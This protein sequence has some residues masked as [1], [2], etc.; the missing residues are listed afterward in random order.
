[1]TENDI[2]DSAL[3]TA[4]L[5]LESANNYDNPMTSQDCADAIR[6]LKLSD[7]KRVRNTTMNWQPMKTAP[8]DGTGIMALLPDSDMAV[9]V[10]FTGKYWTVAWDGAIL[11]RNS[12]PV[13]WIH[14][15]DSPIEK[16]VNDDLPPLVYSDMSG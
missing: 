12:E 10:R 13:W 9:G 8:R 2:W 1:M 11:V 14:I 16:P 4:A 5:I 3:E 7:G 6:A 15:P